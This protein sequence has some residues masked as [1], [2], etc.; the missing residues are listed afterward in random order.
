MF[1]TVAGIISQ[2]RSTVKRFPG[3]K[4]DEVIEKY[5]DVSSQLF[6]T[7]ATRLQKTDQIVVKLAGG[8]V[9]KPPGPPPPSR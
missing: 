9:R 5:P 4:L 1:R 8:G 3:E 2:G 7:M 6:R